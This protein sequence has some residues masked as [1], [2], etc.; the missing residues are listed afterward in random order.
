MIVIAKLRKRAFRVFSVVGDFFNSPK[1]KV[2]SNDLLFST[3]LPITPEKK[4]DIKTNSYFL[5]NIVGADLFLISTAVDKVALNYGKE[6]QIDL[7][8]LTLAE[9][10]KYT[11]EGHFAAGSMGPKMKAIIGFFEKGGKEALITCPEK[12]ADALK[13]KTGTRITK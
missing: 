3:Y 5:A 8:T 6:N 7:D 13:G 12:I 1:V 10:K 9:A 2:L 4:F 11:E